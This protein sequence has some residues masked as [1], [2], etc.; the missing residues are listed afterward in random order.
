VSKLQEE[1]VGQTDGFDSYRVS[2]RLH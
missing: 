1:K 2:K